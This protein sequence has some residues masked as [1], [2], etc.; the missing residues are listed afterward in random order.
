MLLDIDP[1]SAPTGITTLIVG[2][3]AAVVQVLGLV[4]TGLFGGQWTGRLRAHIKD[5]L[6]ILAAL[7]AANLPTDD[8]ENHI[9]LEATALYGSRRQVAQRTSRLV[10]W[11]SLVMLLAGVFV[12][13][14]RR[15]LPLSSNTSVYLSQALVSAGFVIGLYGIWLYQRARRAEGAANRTQDTIPDE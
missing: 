9:K 11:I 1:A 7:R 4:L 13:A 6:A 15:L 3:G 8:V 5:D 12:T 10:R 14:V 2:A